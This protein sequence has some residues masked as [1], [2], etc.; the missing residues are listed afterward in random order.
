MNR[1]TFLKTPALIPIAGLG[2]ERQIR[3]AM[4]VDE[5]TPVNMLVQAHPDEVNA[6]RFRRS[7]IGRVFESEGEWYVIHSEY[8]TL[9]ASLA[10]MP[11]T[12]SFHETLFGEAAEEDEYLVGAFRREHICCIVRIRADSEQMMFDI[13]QHVSVQSIPSQLELAWSSSQLQRFIPKEADLKVPIVED[14]SFWP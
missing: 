14:T 4:L 13:A 3:A 5:N 6:E 8:R 12:L 2:P 1:R 9:P 11:G 10:S 7:W